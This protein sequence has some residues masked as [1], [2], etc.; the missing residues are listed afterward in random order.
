MVRMVGVGQ[1]LVA[2]GLVL[3]WAAPPATAQDEE[4]KAEIS[5]E[6]IE[7]ESGSEG[8][9]YTWE[10]TARTQ[11]ECADVEFRLE[12]EIQRADGEQT[13]HSQS[14]RVRISDGSQTEQMRYT[15]PRGQEL[16]EWKVELVRCTPC[17]LMR[18]D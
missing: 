17:V 7:E 3:V 11:A 2:V 8:D 9:H 5:S 10:V 15:M 16:L 12:L 6:L 14:G 1:F 4:C 18:P 13:S